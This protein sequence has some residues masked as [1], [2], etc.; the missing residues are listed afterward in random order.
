LHVLRRC[1][2]IMQATYCKMQSVAPPP[3]SV[4]SSQV[5]AG[6]WVTLSGAT[7][8]IVCY[9]RRRYNR[10]LPCSRREPLDSSH[11]GPRIAW[12]LGPGGPSPMPNALARLDSRAGAFSLWHN[13]ISPFRIRIGKGITVAVP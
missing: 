2:C 3:T 7:R 11:I 6:R 4:L 12:R 10:C 13:I 5:L 9:Y 8:H 1:L